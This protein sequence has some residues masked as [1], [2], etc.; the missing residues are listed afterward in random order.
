MENRVPI[1]EIIKQ[2][3]SIR[4][5]E[6][7]PIP[8]EQREQ[9]EAALQ[10][11]QQGPLGTPL[12]FDLIAAVDGDSSA[13]KGLGTYGMIRNPPGFVVGA[14][15]PGPNAMED[16]GYGM[17]SAILHSTR[18]GLGTCWLGG[19]FNHSRFAEKIGLRQGET[20]PAVFAVGI[21]TETRGTLDRV[22]RWSAGSKKRKPWDQLIFDGAFGAPFEL[23]SAGPLAEALEMLR[24]APS[25]S[26][27]QPWRIVVGEQRQQIHLFVERLPRYRKMMESLRLA[28]LQRVDLGIAMCHFELTALE[29]GE[30][31]E[32]V[33][34]SPDVELPPNTESVISWSAHA[35]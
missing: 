27:K 6:R 18:L 26:N 20:V 24:W 17:E 12:R 4:R 11:I 10:T 7:A 33:N 25:A 3:T 19:T 8:A 35:A 15:V 2:R 5:Y 13:L 14:V 21:G 32:W 22:V 30:E 1:T 23:A 29:A 31:G 28:D 16:Y 9:L 34:A